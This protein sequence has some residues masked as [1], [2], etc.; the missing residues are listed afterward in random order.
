[1]AQDQTIDGNLTI[2]GEFKNGLGYAPGIFLFG[3]SDDF[4]IR[5]FNVAPNQSEFRFA[6]GDDFQPEDRFSI[7]VNYGGSQW[8]Y[9]MVVQGDGKVGIGTSTPGAQLHVNGGAAVFGTNAVTTN[10]DGH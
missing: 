8:H 7:G 1:M 9:R 10:T 4:F 2:G 3:N 6:I 5:R